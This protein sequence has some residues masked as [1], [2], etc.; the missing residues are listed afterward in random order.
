M[1]TRVAVDDYLRDAA[2]PDAALDGLPRA[3]AHPQL[4]P[5]ALYGWPGRVVAAI[6]DYSGGR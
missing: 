5:A 3:N 1:S 4:K 6:A 2:D